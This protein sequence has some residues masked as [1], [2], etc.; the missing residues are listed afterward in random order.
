MVLQSSIAIE[1]WATVRTGRAI[2]YIQNKGK[3][4]MKLLLN[5]KGIYPDTINLGQFNIY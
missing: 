1:E 3:K 4:Q 5:C 2:K